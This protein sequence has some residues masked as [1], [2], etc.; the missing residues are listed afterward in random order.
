MF[1]AI[2]GDGIH[3]DHHQ[4]KRPASIRCTPWAA[5]F[6]PRTALARLLVAARLVSPSCWL[7]PVPATKVL[8]AKSKTR[9]PARANLTTP[10]WL[11]RQFQRPDSPNRF[12]AQPPYQSSRSRYSILATQRRK[13]RPET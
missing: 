3:A 10:P 2:S 11:T 9:H 4:R 12:A 7:V 8:A 5:V 6:L 13:W 1:H